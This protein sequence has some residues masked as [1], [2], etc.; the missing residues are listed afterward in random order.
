MIVMKDRVDYVHPV[1]WSGGHE[2]SSKIIL[3]RGQIQGFYS[4]SCGS[5]G[6]GENPQEPWR[7]GGW[8][9]TARAWSGI[10]GRVK[11]ID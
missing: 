1:N 2:D 11:K 4:V 5:S 3:G 6:T 9:L 7:R 8:R 10:H